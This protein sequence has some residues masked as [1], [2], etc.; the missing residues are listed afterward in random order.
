ML[1]RA[2]AE[3][4]HACGTDARHA[5]QPERADDFGFRF[6]ITDCGGI[7][8]M[9]TPE[10]IRHDRND[11]DTDLNGEH[12]AVAGSPTVTSCIADSGE[13]IRQQIR[14]DGDAD[15]VEAMQKAHLHRVVVQGDV[16]V[17]RGIDGACTDAERDCQQTE[18]N[19]AVGDGKAEQRECGQKCADPRHA[20]CSEL[21]DD[22]AGNKGAEYRAAGNEQ[23]DDARIGNGQ[24]QIGIDCRPCGTE[25][26]VGNSECNEAQINNNEK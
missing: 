15:A 2:G 14:A 25:Q 11:G 19:K 6:G 10:R 23:R 18:P 7:C 13:K 16:I 26:R 22:I 17:Q 5:Q 4:G 21:F 20:P 12:D 24:V 9:Y 8:L 3:E 1:K